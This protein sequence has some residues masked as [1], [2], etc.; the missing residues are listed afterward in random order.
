MGQQKHQ[1]EMD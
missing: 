1:S